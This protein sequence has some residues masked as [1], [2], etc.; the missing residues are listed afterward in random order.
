MKLRSKLVLLVAVAAIMF[1]LSVGAYFLILSPLDQMEGEVAVFQELDR[2]AASA[3]IEASLLLVRPFGRQIAAYRT[4]FDRFHSAQGGMGKV[5]VLVNANQA[6]SDA[7]TAVV[8]LTPLSENALSSVEKNLE[9]L[10]NATESANGNFG[11]STWS[12]LFRVS[13]EIKDSGPLVYYLNHLVSQLNTLNDVMTVTRQVVEK[14]DGEI[15]AEV[16]KIKNRSSLAGLA[17]ILAAV[18]LTVVFSFLLARNIT[19]A[20]SGLGSTVAKVGAGDLRVRFT[21]RRKDE[22]GGLARDIDA[23]LESLTSAFRRIQ[24]A[25]NENLLVKEQLGEAVASATASSVQIE[26]NSTSILGQLQKVDDRLQGSDSELG[27]VVSLIEAFRQRLSAQGRELLDANSAVAELTQGISMVSELSDTS[28]REVETLLTQSDHGREV[29]ER[30]FTKIAEISASVADIQ[31]LV[32]TIAEIAAQTNIL[33]LN[34][35]IEAAHAGEAGKGFAVVADE[36]SKLA[37]ASAENSG[38]IAA[39]IREVVTKILEADATRAETLGAFEAIGVQITRV[40]D[41]SRGI[42]DEADRMN[43]GTHRIRRV[44]ETVT[45]DAEDTVR[46]ADRIGTVAANVGASLG[47]VG[48]ISHEVVS[49]VGEIS[50]GLGEITRTISEVAVQADRLRRV[51]EALDEAVNAFQTDS[52]VTGALLAG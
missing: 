33:A 39:T 14:K 6:L 12:G 51:G 43:Q 50:Q 19:R 8:K 16:S 28:R 37:A 35:A 13:S 48:R 21:S 10:K 15:A 11:S 23:L 52:I 32:V 26:A 36:I 38:Q 3:Q 46:E 49:N 5:V 4:A 25:S 45:A 41:R 18:A 42:D 29:F 20:L 31:D 22:L 24:A 47:L 34:A 2:A 9:D 40:S 44:M 17:I 27:G 7:V 30:S 1:L